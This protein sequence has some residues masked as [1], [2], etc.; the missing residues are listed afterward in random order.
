MPILTE[1]HEEI[2]RAVR[3]FTDEEIVPVAQEL[4]RHQKEIPSE[5]IQK[6]AEL[7]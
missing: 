1:E 4:D 3:K 6:M 7:G 5:I 2:R